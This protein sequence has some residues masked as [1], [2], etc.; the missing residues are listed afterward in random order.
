MSGK[1]LRA[2]MC[3]VMNYDPCLSTMTTG[4]STYCL[5]QVLAENLSLDRC[6]SHTAAITMKKMSNFES[7]PPTAG[8]RSGEKNN[9]GPPASALSYCRNT[10]IELIR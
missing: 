3:P 7:R 10:R 4:A 2:C 8:S 5:Q 9:S 6:V 1:L